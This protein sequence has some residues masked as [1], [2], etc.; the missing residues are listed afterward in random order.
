MD[1][2][3]R[4]RPL[5]VSTMFTRACLTCLTFAPDLAK[6]IID[7]ISH[8]GNGLYHIASGPGV[9]PAQAAGR[10]AEFTGGS[11]KLISWSDLDLDAPRPVYSEIA[12]SRG[13]QMPTVWDAVERWRKLYV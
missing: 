11:V 1:V 10:L 12:T 6:A 9:N 2:M 8:G 5:S 7:I 4:F 3:A 13:I